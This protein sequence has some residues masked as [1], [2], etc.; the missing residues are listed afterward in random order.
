VGIWPDGE[1]AGRLFAQLDGARNILSTSANLFD[2]A[3]HHIAITRDNL[4]IVFYVDGRP[5]GTDAINRDITS[6]KRLKIGKDDPTGLVFLGQI[7]EIRLWDVVRTAAE[8]A[9]DFNRELTGTEAGLVGYWNLNGRESQTAFDI[10]ENEN[11]GVLGSSASS[12]GA[13]PVWA[14]NTSCASTIF[15]RKAQG[16]EQTVYDSTAWATVTITDSLSQNTV[17]YY[18]NPFVSEI[19]MKVSDDDSVPLKITILNAQ[20]VMMYQSDAFHTNEYF[21]IHHEFENGIYIVQAEFG[22]K[23]KEFRI[24]KLE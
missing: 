3:C 17:R 14:T 16:E 15:F 24:V 12:D 13:D 9:A 5:A 7:G 21:T 1:N 8:I 19:V 23:T 4:D 10:T 2:G 6:Q 11:H 20:G 22:G 18:P